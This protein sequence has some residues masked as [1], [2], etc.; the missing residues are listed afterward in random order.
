MRQEFIKHLIKSHKVLEFTYKKNNYKNIIKLPN[1][2]KTN[3]EILN[4]ADEL[5]NAFKFPEY[6]HLKEI[7]KK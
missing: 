7:N 1:Q 6:S 4:F 2:F 5:N 3:K